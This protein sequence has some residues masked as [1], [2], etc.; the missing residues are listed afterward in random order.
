MEQKKNHGGRRSGA[1][2]PANDRKI[3]LSVRIT[4]EAMDLL[5]M[6]TKNKSEYI[7][8]LIKKAK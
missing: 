7:D 3:S 8:R 5:N 4:Q 2:R 6:R 1:G